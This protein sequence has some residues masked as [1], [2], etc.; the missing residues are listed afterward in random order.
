MGEKKLLG[1]TLCLVGMLFNVEHLNHARPKGQCCLHAAHMRT[2]S[3]M[4]L[5]RSFPKQNLSQQ[6]PRLPLYR[7]FGVLCKECA[8]FVPHL[9]C[10]THSQARQA[11]INSLDDSLVLLRAL[12]LA[13]PDRK[14][15]RNGFSYLSCSQALSEGY[16]EIAG[17]Q[18]WQ[19]NSH[20]LSPG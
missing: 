10:P 7:Q 17:R 18:S 3:V 14:S 13:K 20:S 8:T 2:C 12:G 11:L 16:L 5:S 15:C 6:E 19:E 1:R 4:L 9:Q